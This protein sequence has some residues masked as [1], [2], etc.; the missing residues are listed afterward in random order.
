MATETKNI[1]AQGLE[2]NAIKVLLRPVQKA[3]KDMSHILNLTPAYRGS[4]KPQMTHPSMTMPATPLSAALGPA[5]QAT[6]PS[7]P[8]SI[9]IPAEQTYGY[10]YRNDKERPGERE[11]ADT[12]LS[13]SVG[14]R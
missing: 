4:L 11:R 6:V 7:A 10:T 13:R 9:V 8:P 1:A 5:A 12:L 2:I 3:V 14:R